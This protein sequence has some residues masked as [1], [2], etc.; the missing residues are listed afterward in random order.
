[1]TVYWGT[2]CQPL[3]Q[4]FLLRPTS[5]FSGEVTST[6]SW[7]RRGWQNSLGRTASP[8]WKYQ[9]MKFS[10]RMRNHHWISMNPNPLKQTSV[11]N[12]LLLSRVLITS[13]IS[14]KVLHLHHFLAPT[15]R[16]C[17]VYIGCKHCDSMPTNNILKCRSR[18]PDRSMSTDG[19]TLLRQ[20]PRIQKMSRPVSAR[21][22]FQWMSWQEPPCGAPWGLGPS[23]ILVVGPS[24]WCGGSWFW[25]RRFFMV[26]LVV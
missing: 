22:F 26:R 14:P 23:A 13:S 17:F 20:K 7:M 25:S 3:L 5:S 12:G 8:W 1:M 18:F 10:V 11:L 6:T 2:W 21:M 19:M 9:G 24:R 4:P 15:L 16:A